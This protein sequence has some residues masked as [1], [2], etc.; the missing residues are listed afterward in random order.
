[1]D[2]KRLLYSFFLLI[3]ARKTSRYGSQTNKKQQKNETFEKLDPINPGAESIWVD[4]SGR[5]PLHH[6]ATMERGELAESPESERSTG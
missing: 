6:V 3:F 4:K 1:M 2:P 5:N